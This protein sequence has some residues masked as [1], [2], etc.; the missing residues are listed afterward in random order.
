MILPSLGPGMWFHHTLILAKSQLFVSIY[1]RTQEG[2][3]IPL[4]LTK[5]LPFPS[6]VLARGH[7][8]RGFFFFLIIDV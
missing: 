5:A 7:A 3:A 2:L 6:E 4:S 8:H 1:T